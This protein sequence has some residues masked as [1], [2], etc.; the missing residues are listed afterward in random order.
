MSRRASLPGAAE[1]FR[2]TQ[3]RPAFPDSDEK[4]DNVS[5]LPTRRQA[6]RGT[7][8]ERHDEKITVYVSAEELLALESA[9]LTL[10]REHGLAVDR[11][12]IVRHA[13]ALALTSLDEFGDDSP[14]VQRLLNE[15]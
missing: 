13:I 15:D 3:Q 9:R 2:S 6:R 11:G 7:G 12:R 8:R 4:P 5:P 14:L 1:L 10:R